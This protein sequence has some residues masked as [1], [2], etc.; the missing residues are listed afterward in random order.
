MKIEK[1]EI[2]RL[3]TFGQFKNISFGYTASVDENEDAETVKTALM[4]QVDA[5]WTEFIGSQRRLDEINR[6]NQEERWEIARKTGEI[7]GLQ[8][9]IDSMIEFLKVH[10]VDTTTYELPF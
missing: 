2:R 1:V 8:K 4:D 5:D 6:V 9:K 10:G 3:Y 7:E